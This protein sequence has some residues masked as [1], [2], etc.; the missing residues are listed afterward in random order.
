MELSPSLVCIP[1][2]QQFDEKELLSQVKRL[3]VGQIAL[4]ST[5]I[6]KYPLDH[7][8]V[9]C[10]KRSDYQ[11]GRGDSINGVRFCDLTI[12]DNKKPIL[13]QPVA[14]KPYMTATSAVRDIKLMQDLS[15]HPDLPPTFTPVGIKRDEDGEV[16]VLTRFEQGI[17]S[18]DNIIEKHKNHT[19]PEKDAIFMLD[20]ALLTIRSLH[21]HHLTY[22]DFQVKNTAHD[23]TLSPRLID[24][25]T[26]QKR[27]V[28]DA[29]I[30]RF[31]KDLSIYAYSLTYDKYLRPDGA[32]IVPVGLI[33]DQFIDRYAQNAGDIFSKNHLE[34][35]RN[36][37]D[38]IKQDLSDS[39]KH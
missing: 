1:Y 14:I 29:T 4:L 30:D 2:E 18:C 22:G 6:P 39:Y 11:E 15:L 20:I 3:E 36:K 35:I 32:P 16:A 5:V 28:N 24:T 21:A 33:I 34:T 17:T 37:T 9:R 25:E 12:L 26:I 13:T 19:M 7:L 31:I 38:K 27:D 23:M 8:I 10:K